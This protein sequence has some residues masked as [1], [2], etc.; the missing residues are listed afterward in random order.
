MYNFTTIIFLSSFFLILA[1][2]LDWGFLFAVS[3]LNASQE[4]ATMSW[5]VIPPVP[6]YII[7]T[8]MLHFCADESSCLQSFSY[9]RSLCINSVPENILENIAPEVLWLCFPEIQNLLTEMLWR[10]A[11]SQC[12]TTVI[13]LNII[14]E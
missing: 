4:V 14:T 8:S 11:C 5:G 3:Q 6:E 12:V 10:N 13:W 1:P 7:L 2:V 9:S